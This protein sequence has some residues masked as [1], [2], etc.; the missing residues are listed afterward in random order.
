MP[1]HLL[2][3]DFGFEFI[4]GINSR[5]FKKIPLTVQLVEIKYS[6]PKYGILNQIRSALKRGAKTSLKI[7]KK[8][9]GFSS[10]CKD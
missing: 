7:P 2:R 4:N 1:K 3:F 5:D 6:R 8:R 10:I 9:A